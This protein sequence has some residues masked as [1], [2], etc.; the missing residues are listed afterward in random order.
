M[1][2]T[3]LNLYTLGTPTTCTPMISPETR[4]HPPKKKNTQLPTQPIPLVGGVL[5]FFS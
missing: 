5:D 3:L 1:I 4:C 2:G